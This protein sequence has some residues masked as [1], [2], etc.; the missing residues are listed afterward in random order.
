MDKL[1][2]HWQSQG[3]MK[4]HMNQ[5]FEP[6]RNLLSINLTKEGKKWQNRNMY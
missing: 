2:E 6:K 5:F 4:W 1:K 3:I